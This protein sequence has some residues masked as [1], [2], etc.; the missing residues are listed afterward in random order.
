MNGVAQLLNFGCLPV[1][2]RIYD[3]YSFSEWTIFISI[4]AIFSSISTLR[5]ELAI[6][7]PDDVQEALR[8]ATVAIASVLT[9]ALLSV[10]SAYWFGRYFVGVSFY[11]D[12]GQGL[13]MIG[14]VVALQ[15]MIVCFLAWFARSGHFVIY[16][17]GDSCVAIL[18]VSF[19]LLLGWLAGGRWVSLLYGHVLALAVVGTGLMLAFATR[20]GGLLR[21]LSFSQALTSTF[22]QYQ[23]YPRHMVPST[24]CGILRERAIYIL[25][26]N[27]GQPSDTGFYGLANR[28]VNAPCTLVS[29]AIRPVF[30]S[31]AA[32]NDLKD[33]E[34][35]ILKI[36][37]N[38]VLFS[39]IGVMLLVFNY[40]PI[41][42]A[43]FGESWV[44]AGGYAAI[45]S[46]GL[47]PFV[48]GNWLDRIFDI[49]GRQKLA[50]KLEGCFSLLTITVVSSSV[51][52]T[53]VA[54]SGI[55]AQ[56][57]VS[58]T[59][60]TVWLVVIFRIGG[61]HVGNLR[62][63]FL[64]WLCVSLMSL[65]GF[66]LGRFL[67]LGLVNGLVFDVCISLILSCILLT[68]SFCDL[69]FEGGDA[70]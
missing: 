29:G 3:P 58:A 48:A 51:I 50:F 14:P 64:F 41:F 16:A 8:I 62:R 33:L 63:L 6:Y 35:W 17:M 67:S 42:S 45:L 53:G 46:L 25:L 49:T 39:S 19:Q 22:S 12:M 66:G 2:M 38:L 32:R 21:H 65:A 9:L 13:L 44:P 18:T 56:A 68:S 59:Y 10:A 26:A 37:Q 61:L 70:P 28:V 34:R 47:V 15:G 30:Y 1:L 69:K 4:S 60:Y 36:Q 23:T 20:Y 52:C 54:L 7:L 40:E 31:N 11:D 5:L 27:Y 57:V 55:A 43:I 24:L